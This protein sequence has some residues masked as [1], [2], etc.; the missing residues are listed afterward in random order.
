MRV[1]ITGAGGQLGTDLVEACMRAGD[2]VV[3]TD[4]ATL[5]VADRSAALGAITSLRPD[6]VVNCAAWT[7]VDACESDPARALAAN[8]TAV[9]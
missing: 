5:D 4:R 8:G 1:L 3:A 6:A 7:A 2:E 9:R